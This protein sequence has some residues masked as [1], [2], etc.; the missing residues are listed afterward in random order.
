MDVEFILRS[1]GSKGFFHFDVM[2]GKC[3]PMQSQ[4]LN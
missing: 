1:L 3:K 4:M 2:Q